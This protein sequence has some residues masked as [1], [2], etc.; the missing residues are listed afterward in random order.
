MTDPRSASVEVAHARRMP[1]AGGRAAPRGRW[2][3]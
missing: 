1:A 3:H 2:A